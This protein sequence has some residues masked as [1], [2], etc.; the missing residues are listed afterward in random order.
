M[1]VSLGPDVPV[2]RLTGSRDIAEFSVLIVGM[3]LTDRAD[4]SLTMER[5]TDELPI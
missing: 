4:R 5:F 3:A 2:R 1:R